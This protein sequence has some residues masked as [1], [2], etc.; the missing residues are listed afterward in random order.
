MLTHLKRRTATTLG[1][2]V[3][4]VRFRLQG[5]SAVAAG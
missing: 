1:E 2:Y 4:L 5:E 3:V